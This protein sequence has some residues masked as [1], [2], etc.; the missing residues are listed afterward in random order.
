M[1]YNEAQGAAAYSTLEVLCYMLVKHA[2]I[3]KAEFSAEMMRYADMHE[4]TGGTRSP[5]DAEVA[6]AM[7]LLLG[8]AMTA[9]PTV[10]GAA[11]EEG[12]ASIG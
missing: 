12:S 3:P 1:T 9:T 8:I 4:G 7:K 11:I 6:K 10:D 2:I 5:Q